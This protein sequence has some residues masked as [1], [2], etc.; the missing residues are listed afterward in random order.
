MNI[1]NVIDFR[2]PN[3]HRAAANPFDERR[4][5]ALRERET[6]NELRAVKAALEIDP[7][8]QA[9]IVDHQRAARAFVAVMGGAA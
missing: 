5:R 4:A 6:W 3:L 9:L 2:K 1:S 7:N 8:N